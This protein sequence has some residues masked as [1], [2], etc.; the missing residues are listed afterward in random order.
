MPTKAAKSTRSPKLPPRIIAVRASAGAGKTYQLT[1][2]F[3]ELLKGMNLAA[4]TSPR[5]AATAAAARAA[6]GWQAH[7]LREIVAITFTNRAAAE[8][9]DRVILALKEIALGT[10][11]GMRLAAE[12]GLKSAQ[13]AA[14]LEIILDHFGDFQVRTID[15]LFNTL[16]RA[17][18][19][20]M[21]LPPEM[22]VDFDKEAMLDRCLD[23]LLASIAWENPR[24]P[25]RDLIVRL[26]EAYLHI[27]DAPGIV[28]ER[29]IRGRIRDLYD[30]AGRANR[31]P[32]DPDYAGALERLNA[33]AALLVQAMG[34]SG[35]TEC[36]PKKPDI[37]G[38]LSDPRGNLDKA[39]WGKDSIREVATK[40]AETFPAGDLRNLNSL[41]THAKAAAEEFIRCHPRARIFPYLRALAELRKQVRAMAEGEGELMGGTWLER[42]H[43][44][45]STG[46]G[47]APYAL[48]KMGS[49]VRHFLI[50]EF[51]DTSRR[52]WETLQVLIEECLSRGGTFFYVGDVKQAIYGW[53]GGDWKLFG[54][55]LGAQFPVEMESRA[56]QVLETNYRSLP[57][58]VDFNNHLYSVL[59]DPALARGLAEYMMPDKT[60]DDACRALAETLA[61]NFKDVAQQVRP[62]S[63]EDAKDAE[64]AGDGHVC[65]VDILGDAE[66]IAAEVEQ[67]L[68]RQVRD[69]WE[70]RGKGIAILVRSNQQA[71]T[72]AAWLVAEGIPIVTENSLRLKSSPLVKGLVAMLHFLEYPLD[73]LSFWGALASPLFAGLVSPGAGQSL[74]GFLKAGRWQGPL[75]RAFERDFP[76]AAQR[77]VRP[78]MA[79]SG[80]LAPYDLV[81]DVLA[82]FDI[83]RRFPD[84]AVFTNRFLEI[85]FQ[86]ETRRSMSLSSFLQFWDET[87][88]EEQVGLP[89]DVS[90]VR[91]LTIHKSK[92]LEFPVVFVPFT[93]WKRRPD[94]EALTDQEELVWL[95]G[96]RGVPLPP[97]LAQLKLRTT[98][99]DV[100]ANLNLLYVATTRPRE[101]LYLYVTCLTRKESPSREYLSAWLMRMMG[102]AHLDRLDGRSESGSG[103]RGDGRSEAEK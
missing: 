91:I 29:A 28:L 5:P 3:L 30:D 10:D 27:E 35:F 102:Q 63:P 98:M 75:Y 65:V 80:Y 49:A 34:A 83:E 68:R 23:T 40:K 4:A 76:D 70:R 56:E 21:G 55:V 60:P 32:V 103:S 59:L 87:G 25:N 101:E 20:E 12:T 43:D 86:A 22:N 15:S 18:A 81:R 97:E 14:W 54:E 13:A 37:A 92:G 36:L 96:S 74:E 100:V 51:Q 57:A 2:R 84:Q 39:F 72:V 69:A 16:M 38:Y 78:L 41:F 90:A 58:I 99:E 85:V 24:D 46:G 66:T 19:I 45:L 89:E 67:W 82:A 94:S 61:A 53:R 9:K 42:I 33:A 62:H 11:N 31:E 26:V 77:F 73:D 8:M 79:R 93:N 47:T 17:F 6:S 7:A 44:Y 95:K 1:L 88:A 52:Q 48:L 71:E 64:R 50:D